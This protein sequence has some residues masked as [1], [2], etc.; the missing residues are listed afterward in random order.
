[1]KLL[2]KI[3]LPILVLVLCALAARAVIANR[4]EQQTRPRF[5]TATVVEATRL[6]PQSYTVKVQTRGEV[7]AA[8]AGSLVSEVAGSITNISPN[9]VV[10]GKFVK[11]E[12]LV[13]VDPRDYEIALTL[14]QANYAQVNAVLAEEKA[15]AEQAASDWRKLGRKGKPSALTLRKPQLAAAVANLEGAQAQVQRAQLDLDRTRISALYDGQVSAKQVDLGQYVNKGSTLAQIHSTDAA[16]IRLPLTSNQLKF[17]DLQSA[18]ATRLPLELNANVA[19]TDA[20]WKATLARTEGIDAKT[21]QLY[22]VARVN[23]PNSLSNPLRLGQYVEAT[24][25]GKTL[26]NVFVVPRAALR[27]DK[28]VLLVDELGTLQSRDVVVEW[29]DSEVAVISDGLKSGDILNL[30]SLGSVTNGT[31]VSATIDGVAPQVE[32]RGNRPE[33]A[34]KGNANKSGTGNKPTGSNSGN[35]GGSNTGGGNRNGRMQRLKAMIEAG[36]DIPPPARARIEARIAAGE[37]VPPWLKQYIEK[38]SK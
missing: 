31:R 33:G 12:A 23:T 20:T 34:N 28:K 38:T 18:I 9:F 29:K 35:G 25:T 13:Q 14:A 7:S 16:E 19:G 5:K 15:R 26:N 24:V 30:T 8:R 1:M 32:K 11:G 6:S 36:E 21:R 4:P 10:G 2:P 17:I 22:V 37:E 3:L 27:E